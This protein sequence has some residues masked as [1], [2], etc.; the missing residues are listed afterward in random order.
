MFNVEECTAI[1][2]VFHVSVDRQLS[3]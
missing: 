3:Q 1:V 2:F